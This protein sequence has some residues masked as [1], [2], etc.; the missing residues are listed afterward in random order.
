MSMWGKVQDRLLITGA[1]YS[2]Y[3]SKHLPTCTIKSDLHH[4][5][6]LAFG[7]V[8]IIL[9]AF[10]NYFEILHIP[11]KNKDI[12][13]ST[14]PLLL[15][16]S[17][18]LTLYYYKSCYNGQRLESISHHHPGWLVQAEKAAVVGRAGKDVKKCHKGSRPESQI[19]GQPQWLPQRAN[20]STSYL[21]SYQF[22]LFLLATKL[23]F[24]IISFQSIGIP[25]APP[26]SY[27][28][29]SW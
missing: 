28:L 5:F 16:M 9:W 12:M 19:W 25:E 10:C 7:S 17:V 23:Q 26:D 11:L 3:F 6:D 8:K 15:N 24:I 18:S 4:Q 14:S 2:D 29:S 21:K 27:L 13:Y 1:R 22:V 20:T